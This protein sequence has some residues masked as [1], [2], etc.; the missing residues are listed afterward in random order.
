MNAHTLPPRLQGREIAD[1]A[2]AIREACGEDDTAFVDTLDG[3]CSAV[4]AARA[5]VRWV[6]VQEA[7]AEAMKQLAKSYEARAK[8]LSERAGS[9]RRAL[10]TFMQEI[11][12]KSLPLPEATLSVRQGQPQLVGDAD[13]NGLDPAFCRLKREVDRTAI[14]RH[15]ENGGELTG[16]ALSNGAPSLTIRRA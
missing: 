6:D 14:K 9:G 7:S 12:E 2:R 10:L 1:L 3:E 13:P 4:D 5:V 16:F 8:T 15:L 11:G